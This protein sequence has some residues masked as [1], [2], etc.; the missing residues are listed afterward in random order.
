MEHNHRIQSHLTIVTVCVF[1]RLALISACFYSYVILYKNYIECTF[2]IAGGMYNGRH[3]QESD[4]QELIVSAAETT[5]LADPKC[6]SVEGIPNARTP[7]V[8]FFHTPSGTQCDIAF[9]HGLGCENTKL[10]KY[11]TVF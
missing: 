2:I 4:I 3:R 11:D 10:I 1:S 5:L 7:I 9:R 8:K 6:R